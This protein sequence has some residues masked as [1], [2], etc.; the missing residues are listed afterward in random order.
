MTD[1]T[2]GNAVRQ[3]LVP[4]SADLRRVVERE[5]TRRAILTDRGPAAT[6]D[7]ALARVS[8]RDGQMF[9]DAVLA[10]SEDEV[11]VVVESLL[12]RG[13]SAE[14]IYIELLGPTAFALGEMWTA[15]TCDFVD[16]TVGL[17]RIQRALR[18]LSR[19]FLGL[20]ADG[21]TRNGTALLSC[22]PGEQ[23][24]LGLFLVAEFMMRDG[25]GVS[26][27]PPVAEADLLQ[28]VRNEWFDVVGFSVACDT[29][30][31]HLHRIIRKVRLASR[32]HGVGV[33]VGG[34][35][36]NERPELVA[37]V[38]ADVS[39]PDAKSAS[40][41]ARQLSTRRGSSYGPEAAHQQQ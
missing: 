25:W 41:H 21:A 26:L 4:S 11:T 39:A 17:G 37:R 22:V 13:V 9:L 18:S 35:V 10:P 2:R 3:S 29:R 6:T 36:F 33:M 34:R 23:H 32:N 27:G 24:T 7:A 5:L 40:V 30:L 8:A 14:S 28:L 12:K 20:S 15:D 16:V 1:V 31:S 19:V 38:G